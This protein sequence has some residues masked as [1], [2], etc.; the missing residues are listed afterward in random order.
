MSCQRESPR[1][2]L[3][4]VLVSGENFTLVRNLA[5][6]SCKRET[7]TRFGVNRKQYVEYNGHR[8]LRNEISCGVPQVSILGP[9]F[10]TVH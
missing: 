10:L 6:V 9:I 1:R 2:E 7:T 8:S 5:A 4:L 3:T